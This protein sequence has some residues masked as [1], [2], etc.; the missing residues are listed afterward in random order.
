MAAVL[1]QSTA[2]IIQAQLLYIQAQLLSIQAQ[3]ND[4]TSNETSNGIESLNSIMRNRRRIEGIFYPSTHD[5][6]I[7]QH[8]QLT[9]IDYR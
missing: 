1:H 3:Q 5:M 9:K 2:D 4:E 7:Q 6:H 8:E